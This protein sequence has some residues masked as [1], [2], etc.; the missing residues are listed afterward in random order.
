MNGLYR[1][2]GKRAFDI[3]LVLVF[4]VLFWWLYLLVAAAVRL[5]LGSPVVFRQ[6]RPGRRDP[7]TGRE[8]LFTLYKF[9][10]MADAIGKDGRPLPDEERLT[11][12]GRILRKTSLDELPELWNILRGD[13]SFVGP[14][15]LLV[16]YLPWYTDEER[17]RHDVLPGLT[18]LAQVSG[19]NAITWEQK[20][21]YDLQYVD[22]LSFKTDLAILAKTA[23][24][25]LRHTSVLS[26]S[27]QVCENLDV[28]R[29]RAR[30]S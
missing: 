21:A 29:S 13:M 11:R 30:Q 3:A 18:G 22:A 23:G 15:P 27:E 8:K 14:R 26:G 12:F 20:F 1:R 4:W 7:V 19:R 10:T 16:E 28:E 25:V 9:R 5:K 6:T 24:V 17:R 2:C